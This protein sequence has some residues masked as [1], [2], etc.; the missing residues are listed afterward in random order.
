MIVT[1]FA[2]VAA[3]LDVQGHVV[4]KTIRQQRFGGD[5]H[6]A[7]FRENLRAGT[8]CCACRRTRRGSVAAADHCS[9]NGAEQSTAAHVP[10][11]LLV[12]ADT[13]V[14]HVD[15]AAADAV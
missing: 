15:T 5:A 2:I 1:T 13:A 6:P 3:V 11:G 12:R 8:D 10:R 14:P 9:E 4:L 7:A